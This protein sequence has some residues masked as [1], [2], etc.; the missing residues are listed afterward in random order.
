MAISLISFLLKNIQSSMSKSFGLK[1]Y[2]ALIE[3]CVTKTLSDRDRH[4]TLSKS[5]YKKPREYLMNPRRISPD[6]LLLHIFPLK[7]SRPVASSTILLATRVSFD[8]IGCRID[9]STTHSTRTNRNSSFRLGRPRIVS[10]RRI[11]A[12]QV[13]DFCL[14]FKVAVGSAYVVTVVNVATPIKV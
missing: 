11:S 1:T 6:S 9:I 14:A 8:S 2:R 12:I 7:L 13:V 5:H 3:I 4:D 10:C